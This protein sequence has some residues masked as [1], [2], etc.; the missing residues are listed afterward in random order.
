MYV[1]ELYPCILFV[2]MYCDSNHPLALQ[3]LQH[4]GI[5][6]KWLANILHI[7]LY[8]HTYRLKIPFSP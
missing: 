7:D 2:F 8:V 1:T 3:E 5:E 6:V 4:G